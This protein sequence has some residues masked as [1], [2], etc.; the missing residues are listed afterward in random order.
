MSAGFVPG[1]AEFPFSKGS[2]I[3]ALGKGCLAAL[4]HVTRVLSTDSTYWKS[5]LCLC[6]TQVRLHIVQPKD[7]TGEEREGGTRNGPD[8]QH[9]P[10]ILRSPM[11]QGSA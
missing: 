10:R 7:I 1:R 6:V 8:T 3:Q 9:L 2:S 11:A 4:S 5:G